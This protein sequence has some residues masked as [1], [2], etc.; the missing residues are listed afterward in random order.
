LGR[1]E[2]A[3]TIFESLARE[4]LETPELALNFARALYHQ[5]RT[6]DA[7]KVLEESIKYWPQTNAAYLLLARMRELRGLGEE[8]AEPFEQA[9]TERPNDFNLR[10]MCADFLHRQGYSARARKVLDAAPPPVTPQLLTALGIVLDGLGQGR[11]AL[12][13][14]RRADA[15][16]NGSAQT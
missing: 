6:D 2:E 16:T 1:T 5:Q 10:L 3:L 13:M 8:C 15:M 14:L 9:L 12:A 11:D 4:D 7:E